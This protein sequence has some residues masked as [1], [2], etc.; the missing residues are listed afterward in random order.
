MK[1]IENCEWITF[2]LAGKELCAI[3]IKGL[4]PG[5]IT[6]TKEHLA[7]ENGV[8]PNEIIVGAE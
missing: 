1:T 7:Y 6:A 4:F 5:E 2:S 8:C 3:T